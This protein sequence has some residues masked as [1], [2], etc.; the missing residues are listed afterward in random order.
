M[1][2]NDPKEFDNPNVFDDPKGFLI[3][4]MNFDNPKVYGDA[5]ITDDLVSISHGMKRLHWPGSNLIFKISTND[6][7]GCVTVS[8][9]IKI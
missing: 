4:S 6:D 5:S 7:G 9:M 3:G 1:D 8:V 2:F